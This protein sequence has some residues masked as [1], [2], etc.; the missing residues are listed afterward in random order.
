MRYT[1][2]LMAVGMDLRG[3]SASAAL[4]STTARLPKEN[5]STAITATSPPMPL[6]NK[7]PWVHR[8]LTLACSP[9]APETSRY[10]PSSIMPTM[11][12]TL[13]MANQNSASPKDFT[14]DRLIRLISTK[15]ASA[16][17]QVGI[18]GYQYC[19]YLPTAVSSA[20]PTRI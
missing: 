4:M 9:P 18:S 6:G 5:T 20:M 11:A 17:A 13:T 8:L 15:K 3:F 10:S 12:P 2:W 16:V 1:T 19:T 7:P 14:W